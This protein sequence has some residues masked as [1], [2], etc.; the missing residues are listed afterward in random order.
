M[1]LALGSGSDMAFLPELVQSFL[2]LAN[3]RPPARVAQG[4]FDFV[5]SSLDTRSGGLEIGVRLEAEERAAKFWRATGLAGVPAAEQEQQTLGSDFR[6]SGE[7]LSGGQGR[8]SGGEVGR[9]AAIG[10]CVG[11]GRGGEVEEGLEEAG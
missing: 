5:G 4:G 10:V 7:E 2:N 6:E 11:P 9:L 1:G 3:E 8:A